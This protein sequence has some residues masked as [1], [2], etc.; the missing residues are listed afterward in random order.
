MGTYVVFY[1]P[2]LKQ[3]VDPGEINDGPIKWQHVMHAPKLC[4]LLVY[5]LTYGQWE[6]VGL[7]GDQHYPKEGYPSHEEITHDV[8]HTKEPSN[9]WID[10][11]EQTIRALNEMLEEDEP[12]EFTPDVDIDGEEP[13]AYSSFLEGMRVVRYPFPLHSDDGKT[14]RGTPAP[15]PPRAFR[16]LRLMISD[17]SPELNALLKMTVGGRPVIEGPLNTSVFKV[18]E[19]SYLYSLGVIEI[20]EAVEIQL[21]L[22]VKAVLLWLE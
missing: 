21:M 8:V 2:K 19:F 5:L 17:D 18:S 20:G 14:W 10:V 22:P 1:E 11:T 9:G 3:Y 4:Q 13:G 16:I 6:T 7:A 15:N 12:I